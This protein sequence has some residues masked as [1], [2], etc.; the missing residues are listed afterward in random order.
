[1]ATLVVS[2]I[3]IVM[4]VAGGITLS[5]G[6]LTSADTTALSVEEISVREGEI[7]RT[8][9]DT[10]R[11]AYLSWADR[12]RLT[13]ANTGQ[14]RLAGFD[15]WDIIVH[16]YD[17]TGTYHTGWFPY[18]TGVLG[19]NEWKKAGIYLNGPAESFEP[20]IVNPGEQIV[21]LARLNP[22]PGDATGISVTVATPNGIRD[23]FSFSNPGYAI[24]TPHTENTTVN[25]TAYYQ[26]EEAAPG[27]AAGTIMS[28]AFSTGEVARK[29]LVNDDQPSRAAR[30]VFPLVGISDIPAATWNFYY[31]CTVFGDGPFPQNGG[32]VSFDVDILIR[33][34]DGTI[35]QTIATGAA[36]AM[37]PQAS[38][39]S[40][41]TLRGTYAFPGY[42]VVDN[43]DYL[44][45]AYYGDVVSQGPS[46]TVGYTQVMIDDDSL[47]TANQTRTEAP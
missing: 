21:I 27:D 42:T 16:Y 37:F 12:L 4:I 5:Q 28:A 24:L 46:G 36:A 11:A 47:P 15:K 9:V 8:G 38:E 45:I 39:G 43:T 23:S 34:A 32:D 31:R 2:I 1:M 44:E 14:T 25:G 17:G 35:R 6:I 13:V 26:L 33:R 18:T 19:D 30:H 7:M 20:G 22:L 3:V 10:L 40:W 29:L 41:V